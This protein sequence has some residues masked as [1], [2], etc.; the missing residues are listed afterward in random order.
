MNFQSSACAKTILFGEH[1]VVYDEPAVAV[2][3]SNTRTFVD[4]QFTNKPFRIISGSIHLNR[5]YEELIPGS[6]LHVLLSNLQDYFGFAELPK[7]TLMI[8]SEIPIA[9]GLG[10]GA[11]L[12]IAIIRSFAE[13]F[14]RVLPVETINQMAYE[15][16]KVYHGTPSGIDNTTIAYE[17][18][19]IFSKCSG[20]IPLQADLGKLNLLVVDSGI[21]SRTI[22]VVSD[23]RAN[24]AKNEPFIRKIGAL[25]RS[26]VEFLETGNAAELGRLM[27]ENQRLLRMIDVSSPELDKLIEMGI[28]YGAL[29]GKLTGAG[30]GGNFFILAKDR[31]QAG[32]LK[33]L[34]EIHGYKVIQ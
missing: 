9:S 34:Y 7:A 30:R 23:V 33:T 4:I 19:I 18:P 5:T 10:S 15:I 29:G 8:R 24:F 27:N 6:G 32:A 21:R 13:Y 26:S 12:S 2:P 11:A 14:D 1:A 16:E 31:E 3:I 22:D 17:Q 28:S 20:F 25:V